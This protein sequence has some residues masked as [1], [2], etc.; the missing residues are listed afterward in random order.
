MQVIH[1]GRARRFF[2]QNPPAEAPLKQW[3]KAVQMAEWKN[4]ADVKKTFNTADWV[5]GKIVFDIKGNDYRLIAI[6]GF[7]NGK[8]Y[9]KRVVTHKD[10][11]K[12]DWRSRGTK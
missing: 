9:I 7:K 8:L 10:Y 6:A 5:D 3:R 2:H 1:W 4:F 11:E 12:D